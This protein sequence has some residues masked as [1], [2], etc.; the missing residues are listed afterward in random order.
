MVIR[1]VRAE[2]EKEDNKGRDLGWLPA[3]RIQSA[4]AAFET[5]F[6]AEFGLADVYLVTKKRG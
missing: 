1:E 4:Y 5:I 2:A 6:A 3:Y